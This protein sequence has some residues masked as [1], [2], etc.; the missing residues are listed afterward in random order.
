[1]IPEF[2]MTSPPK[3]VIFTAADDVYQ[4][5]KNTTKKTRERITPVRRYFMGCVA[6]GKSRLLIRHVGTCHSA[7]DSD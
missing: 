1:M 4:G 2:A 3:P 5:P 7:F 6:S